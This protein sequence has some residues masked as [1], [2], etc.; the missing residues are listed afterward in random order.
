LPS[1][2][3]SGSPGASSPGSVVLRV[4]AANIAFNPT[5][6][7]DAPAGQPFAIEFDNQDPGIPHNVEIIAPAGGSV[8]KGEIFSGAASRTYDVPALDAG[9][10][11][12]VCSV[13]PNMTGTLKVAQ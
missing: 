7:D 12:F 10:Y 8:F 6:L 1:G 2:S 11:T 9:D 5:K 13:H 4:A 3:P